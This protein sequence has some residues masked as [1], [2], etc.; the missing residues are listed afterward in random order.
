MS[1]T[2]SEMLAKVQEFHNKHRFHEE[3]YKGHDMA[4]RILLT[5]EELGEFAECF[6]K[7]KPDSE[8]AEEL[9][10]LLILIIGHA[11]AMKVD[12]E[13]AFDQKMDKIMERP[14]IMGEFG[15]RVT[16]YKKD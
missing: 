1:Q 8:K 12:L 14:A 13:V 2:Y 6:T 10:D 7:G 5:V 11:I 3:K 16:E 15:I 4:Y 9:A